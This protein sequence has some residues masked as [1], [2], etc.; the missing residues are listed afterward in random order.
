[1]AQLKLF[2]FGSFFLI[3]GFD[4]KLGKPKIKSF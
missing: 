3:Q 4:E 2:L 1:M